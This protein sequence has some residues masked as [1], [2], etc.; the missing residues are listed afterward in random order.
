MQDSDLRMVYAR[1]EG[2]GDVFPK[3]R[4]RGLD[5]FYG[6]FRALKAVDMDISAREITALIGPSGC[7]KS[8][9]LKTLNRM[10]DLVAG[11][12][13]SGEVLLDG[14]DIYKSTD[15]NLL[16]KRVVPP[17]CTTTSHT[18]QRPTASERNPRWTKSSKN[19]CAE[20]QSGTRSRT[21]SKRVRSVFR[22]G[23]NRG[24]A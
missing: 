2:E 11:C 15:V 19:P 5:L 4:V 24:C 22:A 6:N 18:G 12:R 23:N 16:R 14:A 3:F 7:G 13:I 10:N 17:A 1:T 21:G 8:T 20:P 9:F